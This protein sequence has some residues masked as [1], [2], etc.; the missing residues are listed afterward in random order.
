MA[1]GTTPARHGP[2]KAVR[3]AERLWRPGMVW[4]GITLHAKLRG[5]V[6]WPASSSGPG[7]GAGFDDCGGAPCANRPCLEFLEAEGYR[8]SL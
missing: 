5:H 3:K 6:C 8:E 2:R 4:T 1:D 7:E